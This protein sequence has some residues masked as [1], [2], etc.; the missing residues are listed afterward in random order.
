MNFL[1]Q[2]LIRGKKRSADLV[3]TDQV[4][5]QVEILVNSGRL[6]DSGA[7]S[8]VSQMAR[9]HGTKE[10]LSLI[11]RIHGA[12]LRQPRFL[13]FA[14][15][16]CLGCR[17]IDAAYRY[18]T[19]LR[20]D[21][22]QEGMAIFRLGHLS[23]LRGSYSTAISHLREYLEQD[24][25]SALANYYLGLSH[26]RQ[27]SFRHALDAFS[28]SRQMAPGDQQ[29]LA[30]VAERGRSRG[31]LNWYGRRDKRLKYDLTRGWREDVLH[32][33]LSIKSRRIEDIDLW[34]NSCR[35]VSDQRLFG[36]PDHWQTPD[37][38][39]ANRLGDCE[40][41]A[42][43]AWVQLLRQ[44]VN[45]RFVIG[46]MYSDV[47]NHAWV[48]IYSRGQIQVFECTP[49]EVNRPINAGNAH[50]YRPVVSVDKNL[51]TYVHVDD[52]KRAW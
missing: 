3:A 26:L 11:S 13:T 52:W 7:I 42:L 4:L 51:V 31:Q 20:F 19:S 44:G 23:Y 47:V 18:A 35:Y 29:W 16:Y 27:G 24:P 8:L 2:R 33:P 49:S 9:E 15:D 40:D 46:G 45:A 41:F 48:Q 14:M 17:D 37:A 32:A 43:W 36:T 12:G 30:L 25:A 21:A 1:L 22:R 38:L 34:I 5:S 10:V 39:E 28:A 50:E 6:R